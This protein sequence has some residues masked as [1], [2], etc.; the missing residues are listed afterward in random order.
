MNRFLTADEVEGDFV[1]VYRL[2]YAKTKFDSFFYSEFVATRIFWRYYWL[3]K[4]LK[5]GI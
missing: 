5:I 4:R 3:T 1:R 2:V